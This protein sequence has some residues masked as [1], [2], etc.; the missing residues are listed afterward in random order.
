MRGNRLSDGSGDTPVRDAKRNAAA[1]HALERGW[2]SG[3]CALKQADLWRGTTA[4]FPIRN[5]LFLAEAN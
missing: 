5:R 4:I 2:A 1:G 3:F